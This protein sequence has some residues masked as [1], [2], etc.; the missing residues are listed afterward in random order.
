[1]RPLKLCNHRDTDLSAPLWLHP[2]KKRGTSP[3]WEIAMNT[4]PADQRTKAAP[5]VLEFN[6]SRKI[7][8][9]LGRTGRGLR[10]AGEGTQNI[11]PANVVWIGGNNR[12]RTPLPPGDSDEM[13]LKLT[14]T[15]LTNANHRIEVFTIDGKY[16]T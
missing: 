6:F 3:G 14:T 12:Y 2:S 16:I 10:L 13:L 4:V 15:S 7:H 5:P 8:H 1:M 9:K 11:D